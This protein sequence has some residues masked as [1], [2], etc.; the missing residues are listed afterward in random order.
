MTD[1]RPIQTC[2]VQSKIA[3]NIYIS[4]KVLKHCSIMLNYKNIIFCI[5]RAKGNWKT[6]ANIQTSVV[7]PTICFA[8]VLARGDRIRFDLSEGL[9][10]FQVVSCL[11]PTLIQMFCYL[12]DT[13]CD[14]LLC[15]VMFLRTVISVNNL[16][17]L[18]VYAY[19]LYQNVLFPSGVYRPHTH[20]TW[21]S[22]HC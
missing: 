17:V 14:V 4:L 7:C 1:C 11:S 20:S 6:K 2:K 22:T 12:W 13:Q 16:H 5:E 10:Q 21:L 18:F 3:L 9:S 15:L 19:T 8:S